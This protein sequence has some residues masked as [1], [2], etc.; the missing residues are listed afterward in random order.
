MQRVGNVK[1]YGFSV[2]MAKKTNFICS[3]KVKLYSNHKNNDTIL[4]LGLK[5]I[6]KVVV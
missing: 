4:F 3:L 2:K 6:Y 1:N 5:S